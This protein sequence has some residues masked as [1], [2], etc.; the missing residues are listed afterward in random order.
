MDH[1]W[2]H[3]AFLSFIHTFICSTIFYTDWPKNNWFSTHPTPITRPLCSFF[4]Q[5]GGPF[6]HS[7]NLYCLCILICPTECGRMT[8]NPFWSRLQEALHASVSLTCSCISVMSGVQNQTWVQGEE[9]GMGQPY[10]EAQL[11]GQTHWVSFSPVETRK[12]AQPSLPEIADQKNWEL[13]KWLCL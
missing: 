1:S 9:R 11:P 7:F 13:N 5:E 8:V 3:H 6:H 2:T 10:S 4:L 12:A